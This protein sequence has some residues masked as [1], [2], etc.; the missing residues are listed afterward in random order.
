[1]RCPG[2]QARIINFVV[3]EWR[4]LKVISRWFVFTGGLI[5]EI[6]STAY[7]FFVSLT[8]PW[9]RISENY[10]S[11]KTKFLEWFA[12]APWFVRTCQIQDELSVA[13]ISEFLKD[14]TTTRHID[15]QDSSNVV[16]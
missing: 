6:F 5:D 1:M 12:D 2:N 4:I 9:P 10:K 13:S 15:R 16:L 11:F 3:G 7:Y 8:L 14:F